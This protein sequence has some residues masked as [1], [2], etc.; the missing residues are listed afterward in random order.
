MYKYNK[1][2]I[3]GSM[4]LRNIDISVHEAEDLRHI[5]YH[6]WLIILLF[7]CATVVHMHVRTVVER[8]LLPSSYFDFRRS[9]CLA[10]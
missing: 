7:L 4:Y 6:L 2:C 5:M 9:F 8:R 3:H 10:K 1:L